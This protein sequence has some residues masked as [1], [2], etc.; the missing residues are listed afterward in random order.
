M[1]T[2][3]GGL[4]TTIHLKIIVPKYQDVLLLTAVYFSDVSIRLPSHNFDKTDH[5]ESLFK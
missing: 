2:L 3:R 4:E 1:Q 5:S